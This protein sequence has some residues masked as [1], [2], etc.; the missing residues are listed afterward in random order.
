MTN[1]AFFT[2]YGDTAFHRAALNGRAE[3]V[4]MLSQHGADLN[5]INEV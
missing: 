1:Y 5:K 3:V 4:E 2:Q